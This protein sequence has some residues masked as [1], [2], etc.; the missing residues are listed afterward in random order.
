M[1]GEKRVSVRL[2]LFS[3]RST[4]RYGPGTNLTATPQNPPKST[5]RGVQKIEKSKSGQN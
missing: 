5:F 2:R 3:R 4:D 1:M